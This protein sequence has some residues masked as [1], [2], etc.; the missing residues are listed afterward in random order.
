MLGSGFQRV[1]GLWVDRVR[2]EFADGP[3]AQQGVHGGS[4]GNSC[5]H[6]LLSQLKVANA[7]MLPLSV[8]RVSGG[9]Y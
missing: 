2:L 8:K 3:T 4:G 7:S 1:H 6:S 9:A 5:T